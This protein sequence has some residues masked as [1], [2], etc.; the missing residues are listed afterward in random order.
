MSLS[1]QSDS[2]SSSQSLSHGGVPELLLGLAY[3]ATTGR[4]SVEVIKGSHFRNLALNRPPGNDCNNRD[5]H[6]MG[7][8]SALYFRW[9]IG[10]TSVSRVVWVFDNVL[11]VAA[12]SGL[13]FF[14]SCEPVM[15][16]WRVLL[17]SELQ[18]EDNA[19][20]QFELTGSM[21]HL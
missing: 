12:A 17:F 18:S 19:V 20:M 3:N 2:A 11:S 15:M 10:E 4:L 7:T 5:H 9:H 14:Q 1:A 21:L 16:F 6:Y 8:V 13:L